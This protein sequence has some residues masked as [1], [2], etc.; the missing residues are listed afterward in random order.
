MR[1]VTLP[2]DLSASE[3]PF[4]ALGSTVLGIQKDMGGLL[5]SGCL[6]GVHITRGSCYLGVYLG[7]P[8][9]PYIPFALN[10]ACGGV[11]SLTRV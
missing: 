3:M 5:S 6:I 10:K 9:N 4:G 7:V 2:T 1:F 11:R 8:V